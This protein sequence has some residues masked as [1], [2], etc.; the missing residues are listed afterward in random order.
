VNEPQNSLD[1]RI[2]FKKASHID[3]TLILFNEQV[4]IYYVTLVH[5]FN[6]PLSF[7]YLLICG[8]LYDDPSTSENIALNGNVIDER[9]AQESGHGQTEFS[10]RHTPG[11]TKE[12]LEKSKESRCPSRES[13]RISPAYSSA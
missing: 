13:N 10:S 3:H 8:L 5:Y 1:P 12:R 9:D 6:F 2:N 11:L 7:I 4:Q